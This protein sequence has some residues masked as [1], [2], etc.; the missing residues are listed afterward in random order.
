MEKLESVYI[1][2]LNKTS[3]LTLVIAVCVCECVYRYAMCVKGHVMVD[4]KLRKLKRK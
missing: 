3:M 2:R 4:E 1:R